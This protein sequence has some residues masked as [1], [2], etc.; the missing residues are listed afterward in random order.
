MSPIRGDVKKKLFPFLSRGTE[1]LA[2]SPIAA[3]H[4]YVES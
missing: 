3:P 4:E 1:R 2:S